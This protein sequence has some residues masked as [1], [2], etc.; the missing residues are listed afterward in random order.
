[1][2]VDLPSTQYWRIKFNENYTLNDGIEK[3]TKDI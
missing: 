2:K 3:N 1:M